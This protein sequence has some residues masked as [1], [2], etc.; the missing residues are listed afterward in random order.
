MVSI[1]L[2]VSAS[3]TYSQMMVWFK[4]LR[5]RAAKNI[6]LKTDFNL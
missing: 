1:I 3:L 4:K 6:S 5:L 2:I